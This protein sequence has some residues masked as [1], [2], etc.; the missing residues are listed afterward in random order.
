[1]SFLLDTNVVSEWTKPRPDAG[2]VAWLD[3]ADEDH[4]FLS[5]VTLI[6]LRYGIDRLDAGKRR[7]QLDHWLRNDLIIRFEGRILPVDEPVADV[8]G[9]L[10]ATRQAAGRP[11]NAMD[12]LIAATAEARELA[13]V[14]RNAA[15]F[16]GSVGS[17]VNPWSSQL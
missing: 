8:C 12:A 14:T 1:M 16:E 5:V 10:L 4:I 2:V 13:L 11:M 3:D 6:E 15:D 17:I 7:L 9:K